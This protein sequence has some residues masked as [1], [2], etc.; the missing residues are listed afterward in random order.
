MPLAMATASSL[1]LLPHRA[2]ATHFTP[3]CSSSSSSSCRD[4]CGPAPFSR[5]SILLPPTFFAISILHRNLGL[6]E[7]DLALAAEKGGEELGFK[8]FEDPFDG[9]SFSYPG[10]WFQVRGAGADCFFRSPVNLDESVTVDVSS[11][12]SSRYQSIEELGL[13]QDAAQGLLKQLSTE[14]MSTRLGVRR[15]INVLS[16]RSRVDGDGRLLYEVEVNAK[17]F[18]TNNQMAILPQDRVMKIEWDRRYISVLGVENKRLYQLRLQAPERTFALEG[19]D[20]R[21]IMDSFK[22]SKI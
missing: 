18:A 15:E 3:R 9:Y 5:R 20:L 10:S 1:L 12:S 6:Q 13:P 7:Q 16:S 14:F 22:I 19:D 8:V 11:P 21:R 4:S 17:S 2:H